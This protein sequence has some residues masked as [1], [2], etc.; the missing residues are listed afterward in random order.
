MAG[1]ARGRG[2]SNMTFSIEAVGF[3][4]GESLPPSIL[5]P[6]PLFPPMEH[7]PVPL[8]M[9]VERY[10]DKYHSGEPADNII[11]WKPGVALPVDRMDR[12]SANQNLRKKDDVLLK[13]EE[14]E[15][16][17][18]AGSSEDD[19][20]EEMKKKQKEEETEGE[21]EYEEEEFEEGTDYIMSYFDN[22]EE[23]GGD[24]DE[25]IDE[26]VY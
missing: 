22:G 18:K 5:Q 21:E 24:S 19:E 6:T 13:L 4:K 25:N 23:F 14:L 26:A 2:R 7:T 16:V 3:G 12:S 17:E 8:A 11:D 9:D 10:S 1:R 15:K 20:E